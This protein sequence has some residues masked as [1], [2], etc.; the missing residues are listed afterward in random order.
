MTTIPTLL[1][2]LLPAW[3]TMVGRPQLR[4]IQRTTDYRRV[5]DSFAGIPR[6]IYSLQR[7]RTRRCYRSRSGAFQTKIRHMDVPVWGRSAILGLQFWQQESLPSND[8][9]IRYRFNAFSRRV[10][11]I[12]DA[13]QK[14]KVCF[15]SLDK[16]FR[17]D[18]TTV[19]LL[20]Q[21]WRI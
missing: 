18:D 13:R 3:V 15:Y 19:K 4:Y 6:N 10:E 16:H 5:L 2:L 7:L 1:R 11:G 12:R 21:N 20:V 14:R 17:L 9:N 8:G